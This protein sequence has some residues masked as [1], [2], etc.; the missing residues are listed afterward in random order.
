MADAQQLVKMPILGSAYTARSVNA[1]DNRMINLFPEVVPEGGKEKAFLQRA[2]GLRTLATIGSGPIRGMWVMG[3][4]AYIVSGTQFYKMDTDW[5]STLIGN[6]TGTGPVSMADNGYQ[7]FIACD[8][9][10]FIY[11]SRDDTFLQISDPDFPGAKQVAFLD[12]YFVFFQPG[13]QQLWITA[14]YEGT[15][16]DAL[17]FASAEGN[18]DNITGLIV[19]NRELW[20]FGTNTT[21]VWYNAGTS[22]FPLQRIQGAFNEFGCLATYSV[23]KMDNSVYWLGADARGR[24]MIYRARGYQ[25]ERVSTHAIEWQIQ[26]YDDISNAV[27][28]T[29]QQDGHMFYV[30]SFP[31]ANKTWCYDAA[32][33]SWHERAGLSGDNWM[34]HRSN[35]QMS[36][37]R[38]IVVG[39]YENGKIYAFDTEVFTD[40]GQPQKW[41]RSWRA[42]PPGENNLNRTAHFS[43]QV[44]METGYG[45]VA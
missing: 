34:R 11:N 16:I 19:S 44:D 13:T 29:Y 6:V 8:P 40:D 9:D 3:E 43:V 31:T 36:Y 17:D 41:L 14:L 42:L 23:A 30:I 2:P 28:Y 24:G 21:E 5:S 1:A 22:D 37:N 32:T 7:L 33:Q 18:P 10:G 38:E 27:A 4:Y 35:C 26:N 45:L 15:D 20:L 39:D 12:G 25:A